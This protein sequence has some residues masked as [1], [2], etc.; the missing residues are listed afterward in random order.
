MQIKKEHTIILYSRLNGSKD[1]DKERA[2]VWYVL[3][4]A[5]TK[6]TLVW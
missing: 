6:L 5:F 3:H 1:N 4:V 2:T